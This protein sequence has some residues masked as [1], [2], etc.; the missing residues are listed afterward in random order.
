MKNLVR[1]A[2]AGAML[3]GFATAH[4]QSAPSSN[5][6][7]LWLFVSDSTA[8]TTYAEDLG[9]G[10]TLN[11]LLPPASIL[12]ATANPVLNTSIS[13]NFSVNPTAGLSAYIAA[14]QAAGDNIQW[15]VDG[16]QFPATTTLNKTS[17]APGGIVD[18]ADE[19]ASQASNIST[20]SATN[21]ATIGNGFAGDVSYMASTYVAGGQTYK[22]SNNGGNVGNVWGA[23]TG[24]VG[25]STDLYGQ[26]PDQAGVALGT[27]VDLF[28]LTG[29]GTAS[30]QGE[31]YVLGTNLTLS[32]TGVLSVSA[33]TT[34]P[35]PVPL[36]AAVWLFGSGLL[37][38]IGVGRRR[39]A[40]AA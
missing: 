28:G 40:T 7:D 23:S 30:G 14:A 37:G 9:S 31:S 22:W 12:P 21:L 18:I 33:G 24:D 15:A 39:A 3:A 17:K 38:L 5:N 35:P 27:A 36:P 25:G 6:A 32:S 34:P 26:G 2:V 16:I 29:N 10:Y 13:A 11:S 8:G 19:L 1:F 20:L 4:A